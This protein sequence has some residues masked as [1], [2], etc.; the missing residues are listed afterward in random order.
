MHIEDF[1]ACE[2]YVEYK[3]NSICDNDEDEDEEERMMN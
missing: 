2:G 1:A 3:I